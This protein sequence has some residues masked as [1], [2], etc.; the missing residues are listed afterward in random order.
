M[1]E[2]L[3]KIVSRRENVVIAILQKC[4]KPKKENIL[5]KDDHHHLYIEDVKVVL[6]IA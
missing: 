2:H 3:Q 1:T 5:A 4:K 6:P